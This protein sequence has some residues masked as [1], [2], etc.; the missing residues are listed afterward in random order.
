MADSKFQ[1][2]NRITSI[3]PTLGGRSSSRKRPLSGYDEQM[4]PLQ[5]DK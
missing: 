1:Q 4:K 3:T 2:L 5:V